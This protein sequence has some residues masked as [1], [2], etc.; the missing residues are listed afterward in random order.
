MTTMED[1][2]P[3][4]DY[5]MERLDAEYKGWLD[6]RE[7]HG[8]A[9]LAKAA[10]AL[11]NHGGGYI[12]IGLDE[13]GASFTSRAKPADCPEITQ[14]SVN[15]AVSRYA[16]PAF[17]CAMRMFAHNET[18]VQHP[19]I[20]VPGTLTVPVLIKRDEQGV[21]Q[22]N[23]CYIRKPGPSSEEPTTHA[24]WRTLLN[25]CVRANRD[26]MLDAIRTIVTGQLEV[27]SPIPNTTDELREF[28]AAANARWQELAAK[29]PDAA[30]ARFPYGYYEVGLSLV[31]A[32]PAD[33]LNE[34]NRRIDTA[35]RINLTGWP[36][37][38]VMNT[39]K[40]RPYPYGSFTEAWLGNPVVPE[41]AFND[42]AHCDF[43]RTAPD[44]KMY[45]IRGYTEDDGRVQQ[46]NPPDSS[47]NVVIPVW[48]IGETLLFAARLAETFDG[49]E[50]IA[51]QCRF[52]GLE[53]RHLVSTR[54]DA[55]FVGN[56]FISITDSVDLETRATAQQLQDNLAEV[57]HSLLAPL[58][59]QFSF[60]ELPLPV[61]QAQL[62]RMRNDRY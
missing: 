33:T 2:R 55:P 39:P 10:I 31:G 23:R 15:S 51:V 26:E 60:Y 43:W 22:Q 56:R 3:L 41:R 59:E 5:P 47:V 38:L 53:G 6:L 16:E 19:V 9:T 21:I 48:R 20:I 8:R 37:F 34:L 35:G 17:Q 49:V 44:G 30:P 28:C 58:Y 1:F 24:E 11:A 13:E 36:P 42:A 25:R 61:V 54:L 7:N 62:Q 40:W 45:I 50:Q 29:L 32:A 12:V 52:T 4:I 18:G 27:Q 46:H 57:V 14:D